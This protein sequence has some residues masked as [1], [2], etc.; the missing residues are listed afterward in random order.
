M[1]YWDCRAYIHNV[2]YPN[3]NDNILDRISADD[4]VCIA[5]YEKKEG[6]CSQCL[7]GTFK[8]NPSDS[9]CTM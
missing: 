5:G 3:L 4:C 9:A 6:T 7:V 8:T 1:E 2:K